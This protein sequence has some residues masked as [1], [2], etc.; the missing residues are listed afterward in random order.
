MPATVNITDAD[1]R[2]KAPFAGAFPIGRSRDPAGFLPKV[3]KAAPPQTNQERA[4]YRII[5]AGKAAPEDDRARDGLREP[6]MEEVWI[7]S[8]PR[9]APTHE[10]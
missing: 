8:S 7:G 9:F 4:L 6:R 2:A 10:A 3:A 5:K 1:D